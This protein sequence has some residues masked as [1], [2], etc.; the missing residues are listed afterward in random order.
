MKRLARTGTRGEPMAIPSVWS[1]NV[2]WHI[3]MYNFLQKEFLKLI[4]T[5]HCRK[6]SST[7]CGEIKKVSATNRLLISYDVSSLF[8][9]IPLKETTDVAVNLLFEHNPGLNITNADFK[10]PFEFEP[11]GTYFF[12][13]GT[14]CD[15]IDGVA[16]GSSLGPLLANLLW[17]V[18]RPFD[19]INFKN[20]KI[21][22]HRRY[23]DGIIC[24]F[25]CESDAD[26]F[27][28][29]LNTQHLN[30]KFT[31]EKQV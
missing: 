12:F 25:N 24:L 23:I 4:L 21:A 17:A 31:F 26:K 3:N 10:R 11:S 2:P 14:L 22:L 27:F 19:W 28:A 20:V 29:F 30:I 18:M 6:D 13:R 9:C 5:S 1:Q 8:T 15:Q 7:F 16:K